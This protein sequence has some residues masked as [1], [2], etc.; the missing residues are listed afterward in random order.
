MRIMNARD[1]TANI[2]CADCETTMFGPGTWNNG[3]HS[4]R[5][6]H[7][8]SHFVIGHHSP[9]RHFADVH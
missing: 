5:T 9:G 1:I 3:H 2:N 8:N 7:A 4:I 6:G